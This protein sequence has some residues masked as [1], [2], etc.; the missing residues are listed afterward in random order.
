MKKDKQWNDSPQNEKLREQIAARAA[1]AVSILEAALHRT[2]GGKG[3][4]KLHPGP[5]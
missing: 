1:R 5:C 2:G 3:Y 4:I